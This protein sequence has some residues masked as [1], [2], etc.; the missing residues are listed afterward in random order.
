VTAGVEDI[1]PHY[2]YATLSSTIALA[3][4]EMLLILKGD[5]SDEF[6][7]MLAESWE[8]SDDQSIYTFKLYPDVTFQDGTPANAQAVKDSYTRWIDLDGSPVNVITRFCDSPDKMEVVDELT[9]RFNLGSAQ[10]LFL[11]AMASA[12]GPSVISPTAIADNATEQDPYAHEWA[13]LAAVGTGPYVLESNSVNEGMVLRR[14]DGYHRG[15]EGNH[16]DQV[17]FR[18]VPEDATRRQLLERGEA[19]AAAYNLTIDA[20][21]AM[22]SNADLQVVEYPTTSVSWTIMNAPRL[23][24]KEVRQGLSYAFPYDD[25]VNVVWKGLMKRNGPIADSVRGWDP[26]VFLY[27]TDLD[28]AKE[29]ILAGGFAEGQVFEYMVDS[30]LE[31]EQTIAQLFQ[32]NIQQMGFDL[33]LISVDYATLESTIFGDSPADERP[34]MFGG[35]GW[36][37]DYNDPWNQLWPNFTEANIGGGGSNGGY[38]VNPRFE[39]IMAEAASYDTDAQLSELMAEAQNILTEQDPPVIYYGQVIRYTVLGKS[40]QGFVPNPL[41]LD[42][43]N[44][45]DMS[46]ATT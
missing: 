29:L 14:F 28:K 17:I 3:V 4:Y 38:W 35:W 19:D 12:Y 34:H 10:P 9:L 44:F 5:T 43:F 7:P 15:W 1:D 39:D 22:R 21:D 36:W 45:Y 16:F 20:V 33:E 37:P 30:N 40:I 26:N 2:S 25:V 23:L 32:A 11:S 27:Q 31:S 24:T 42:S 46:R 18:V 41:Y 6:D 8:V 13:K